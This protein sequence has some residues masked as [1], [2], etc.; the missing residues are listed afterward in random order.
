MFNDDP[1]P[2]IS[3]ASRG[4]LTSVLCRRLRSHVV[5]TLKMDTR[6]F[7]LAC[8]FLT[9]TTLIHSV[10]GMRSFFWCLLVSGFTS[11]L[12]LE[13]FLGNRGLLLSGPP[14][15]FWPHPVLPGS[16]TALQSWILIF[17]LATSNSSWLFNDLAKLHFLFL[18]DLVKPCSSEAPSATISFS[19]S[20]L[21]EQMCAWMLKLTAFAHGRNLGPLQTSLP[22]CA[23]RFSGQ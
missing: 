20:L 23:C 9:A 4:L 11:L 19:S 1:T 10:A 3:S 21:K 14:G 22:S 2:P 15:Y 5:L 8:L 18:S 7:R 13:R 12:T 16:S 6:L 17:L